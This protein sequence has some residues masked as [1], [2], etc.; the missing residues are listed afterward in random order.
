MLVRFIAV[1]LIG[2]A[3]IDL[4]LYIVTC[5]HRV[6]PV[7]IFPCVL[8]SLPFCAG[9]LVLVKARVIAEWLA[10]KLDL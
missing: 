7:E 5:R 4:V 9:V 10:D 3:T 6:L 1:A 8:K 2:W